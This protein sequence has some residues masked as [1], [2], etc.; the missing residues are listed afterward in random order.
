MRR[1]EVVTAVVLLAIS[2]MAFGQAPPQKMAIPAFFPL[3]KKSDGVEYDWRKIYEAS[4]TIAAPHPSTVG[5]VVVDLSTIGSAGY[6]SSN[7]CSASPT[8]MF[9]CLRQNGVLILGYVSTKCSQRDNPCPSSSLP[10]GWQQQSKVLYGGDGVTSV[11]AWYDSPYGAYIDGIFL[12]EGPS[13]DTSSTCGCRASNQGYLQQ[14]Y[15]ASSS[16]SGLY[17]EIRNAHSGPCGGRACVMINASQFPNDWVMSAANYATLWERP[18]ASSSQNYVT[19]N[20]CPC[21]SSTNCN[22]ATAQSPNN[23]YYQKAARSAHVVHSAPSLTRG[24]IDSIVC[25]SAG[26]GSPMLFV[27]DGTS[28][29]YDHVPS[30][31]YD[32]ADSM[33]NC[34]D[35]NHC[36][37]GYYDSCGTPCG[38]GYWCPAGQQCLMDPYSVVSCQ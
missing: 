36:G 13:V 9:N 35:E 29:A 16:V 11:K 3:T 12:D 5:V 7:P 28:G 27:Y 10:T 15:G 38:M 32:L 30:Y 37:D 1:F 24:Q 17:Q 21:A 25:R 6:P 14:Y 18:L 26:L 8:A 23:W 19:G 34:P 4:R 20:F 33:Q 2:S 22:C 31:F